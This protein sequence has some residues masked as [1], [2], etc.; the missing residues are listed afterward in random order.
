M[1]RLSFIG[2]G[3]A[4]IALLAYPLF[5]WLQNGTLVAVVTV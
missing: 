2:I 5:L 3:S 4:L 1:R